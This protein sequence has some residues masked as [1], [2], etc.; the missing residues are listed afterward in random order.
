MF[1]DKTGKIIL[2]HKA[3]KVESFSRGLARILEIKN[4]KLRLINEKDRQVV[5]KPKS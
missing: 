3:D 1:F 4:G 2:L 5:I